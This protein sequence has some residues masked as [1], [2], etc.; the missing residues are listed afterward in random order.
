MKD[1][2]DVHK[3]VD[4]WFNSGCVGNLVVFKG[5]HRN[6]AEVIIEETRKMH[7]VGPEITKSTNEL[8]AQMGASKLEINSNKDGTPDRIK[9]VRRIP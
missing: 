9:I 5:P 7:E 4:D 1:L 8:F 3:I 6:Y 2:S